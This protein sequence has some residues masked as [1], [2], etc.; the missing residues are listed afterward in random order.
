MTVFNLEELNPGVWF[1]YDKNSK[2][3]VRP[4]SN[5]IFEK[6]ENE[7]VTIIR[8]YKKKSKNGE[9][10]LIERREVDTKKFKTLLWD[11]CIVNWKGFKDQTG[12]EISCTIDMKIKLMTCSAVFSTFIDACTEKLVPELNRVIEEA[13]KN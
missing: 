9:M 1:D 5:E 12:K 3:C 8:E 4:P 11:Y 6:I 10:Q 2:V 13:E 7:A